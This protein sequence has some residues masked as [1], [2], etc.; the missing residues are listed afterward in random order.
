[1][2]AN[3]IPSAV[4][5]ALPMYSNEIIFMLHGSVIA[6]TITIT[7]VLKAGRMVNGQYY[8]AYEG[9]ISLAFI[10]GSH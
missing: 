9:F 6:S 1:M 2:N 3:I 10:L 5:R 4:R 8:V 7:D